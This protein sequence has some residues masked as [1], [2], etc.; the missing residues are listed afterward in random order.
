MNLKIY[1]GVLNIFIRVNIYY[2]LFVANNKKCCKPWRSYYFQ[3]LNQSF[4][5]TP[6][7][8]QVSKLGRIPSRFD[9]NNSNFLNLFERL[10]LQNFCGT[11]PERRVEVFRRYKKKEMLISY[12]DDDNPDEPELTMNSNDHYQQEQL[13]NNSAPI[14]MNI[15]DFFKS[16]FEQVKENES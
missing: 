10:H 12:N 1:C 2:N 13:D 4:V 8:Y 16:D 6:V 11:R 7:A 9:E 14:I 15:F 3:I 5:P